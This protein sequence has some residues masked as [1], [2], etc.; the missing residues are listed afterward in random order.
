MSRYSTDTLLRAGL[1]VDVRVGLHAVTRALV[2]DELG[3]APSLVAAHW[4]ADEFRSAV[5]ALAVREGC[6]VVVA[7]GLAGRYQE[8]L[9][10]PRALREAAA[11]TLVG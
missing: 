1:R 3:C 4:T 5:V 6:L 2:G 10:A 9:L 8:A 7:Q 11:A